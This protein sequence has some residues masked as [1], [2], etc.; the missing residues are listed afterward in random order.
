VKIR[1]SHLV[2]DAKIYFLAYSLLDLGAKFC[3]KQQFSLSDL[4]YV[5]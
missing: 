4:S 2:V 1:M 3:R 5:F